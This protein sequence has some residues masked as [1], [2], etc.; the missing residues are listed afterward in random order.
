M[1]ASDDVASSPKTVQPQEL[2][3]PLRPRLRK[4]LE[5]PRSQDRDARAL[6]TPARTQVALR[7]PSSAR[8]GLCPRNCRGRRR[9]SLEGWSLSLPIRDSAAP[10]SRAGY[11]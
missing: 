7:P 2:R 5:F 11:V 10:F 3:A 6:V 4:P 1:S 9:R 8:M